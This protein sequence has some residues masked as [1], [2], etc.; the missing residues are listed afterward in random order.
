MELDFDPMALIDET[1]ARRR[2][3]RETFLPFSRLPLHIQRRIWSFALPPGP[4][5]IEAAFSNNP[6]TLNP[7]AEP[8]CFICTSPYAGVL[9]VCGLR[10]D[11]THKISPVNLTS[12]AGQGETIY[13][14]PDIDILYLPNTWRLDGPSFVEDEDNKRSVRHLALDQQTLYLLTPTQKIAAIIRCLSPDSLYAVEGDTLNSGAMASRTKSC[15]LTME[16]VPRGNA[17]IGL[18]GPW[19]S[20]RAKMTKDKYNAV[21]SHMAAEDG[22]TPPEL[23][24]RTIRREDL[25]FDAQV[26]PYYE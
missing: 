17:S 4:T 3:A 12:P 19:N 25:E 15:Q 10:K 21:V 14:R 20:G 24:C 18:I 11:P 23:L 8:N 1:L 7:L 22:W 5:I 16:E 9:E 2:R 6:D 13:L 26:R